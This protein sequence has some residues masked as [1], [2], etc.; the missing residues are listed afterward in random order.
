MQLHGG[1]NHLLLSHGF[2]FFLHLTKLVQL[3]IHNKLRLAVSLHGGFALSA[4]HMQLFRLV[5]RLQL[6]LEISQFHASLTE[7][8]SPLLCAQLVIAQALKLP[9][10]NELLLFLHTA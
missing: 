9:S 8:L 4:L 3:A 10:K 1:L 6:G 7:L 2:G 5:R